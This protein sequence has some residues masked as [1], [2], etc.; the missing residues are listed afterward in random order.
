MLTNFNYFL[1]AGFA[2]LVLQLKVEFFFIIAVC[3]KT[4]K[5]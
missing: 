4:G 2:Q 3:R 1:A 5:Y